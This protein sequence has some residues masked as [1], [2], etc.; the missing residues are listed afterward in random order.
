MKT[1]KAQAVST[2]KQAYQL[3]ETYICY[4]ISN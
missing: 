3:E 4:I 2:W 1:L